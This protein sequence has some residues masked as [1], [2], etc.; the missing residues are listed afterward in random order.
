MKTIIHSSNIDTTDDFLD[1]K[2][3]ID[4]DK[5]YRFHLDNGFEPE[6]KKTIEGLIDFRK[7]AY[8]ID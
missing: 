4:Q 8:L 2:S 3:R 6:L 1:K 7:N 5:V